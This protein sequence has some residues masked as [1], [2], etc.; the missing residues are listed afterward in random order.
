MVVEE[1]TE[2]TGEQELCPEGWAK[3]VI[4][5]LIPNTG[6]KMRL[7]KDVGAHHPL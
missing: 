5:C 3:K 4:G 7:T 1:G 2:N 6:A